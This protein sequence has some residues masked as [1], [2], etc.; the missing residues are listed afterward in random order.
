[1]TATSPPVPAEQNVPTPAKS[2]GVSPLRRLFSELTRSTSGFVGL[3]LVLAIVLLSV[4]GP[5]VVGTCRV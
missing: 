2:A 5:M 1:M 4:I 3:C